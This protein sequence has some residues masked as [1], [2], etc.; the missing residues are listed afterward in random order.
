MP[1]ASRYSFIKDW[2]SNEPLMA[3][4]VFLLS[5]MLMSLLWR[6]SLLLSSM[7][8]P[9][10]TDPCLYILS[11]DSLD[12]ERLPRLPC[13]ALPSK[14]LRAFLF[15]PAPFLLSEL[16]SSTTS[17]CAMSVVLHSNVMSSS[18][19]SVF[20][21]STFMATVLLMLRLCSPGATL[22]DYTPCL[23]TCRIATSWSKSGR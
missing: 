19:C 4:F 3:V 21:K 6:L 12:L 10:L 13:F 22:P 11:D 23:N 8:W 16:A 1:S 17:I 14:L 15:A 20:L 2:Y 5:L 18:T 9:F 7:F